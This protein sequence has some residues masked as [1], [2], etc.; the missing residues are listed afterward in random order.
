[1]AQVSPNGTYRRTNLRWSVAELDRLVRAVRL[2]DVNPPASRFFGIAG[3]L[4]RSAQS[5]RAHW[6]EVRNAVLRG[7]PAGSP[8]VAEYVRRRFP[9][10]V[11]PQAGDESLDALVGEYHEAR[12]RADRLLERIFAAAARD[13]EAL[14]RLR[15]TLFGYGTTATFGQPAQAEPAHLEDGAEETVPEAA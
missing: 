11:E 2:E 13:G 4:E 6:L 12:R 9:A 3:S 8:A 14:N 1:V 5:V 15:G 7:Q 10:A